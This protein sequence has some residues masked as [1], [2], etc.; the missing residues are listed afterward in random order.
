M[1]SFQPESRC[2][3]ISFLRVSQVEGQYIGTVTE[4]VFDRAEGKYSAKAIASSGCYQQGKRSAR[5]MASEI[6]SGRINI[7]EAGQILRRR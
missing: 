6:D 3:Q 7:V 5:T 1:D 2:P 4:C